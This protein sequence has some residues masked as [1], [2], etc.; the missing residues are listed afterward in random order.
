MENKPFECFKRN[1]TIPIKVK[2]QAIEFAKKFNN[3]KAADKYGVSTKAI[4]RWKLNEK[5]FLKVLD[6]ETRITLHEPPSNNHINFKLE[7]EIYNWICFNRSLG[8]P[9]TTWAIAIE[10]K[11]K[12]QKRQS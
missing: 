1:R 9:V 7:A 3:Q 8:N 4:R 5:D 2:L 10:V 11:K 6:P 12:I